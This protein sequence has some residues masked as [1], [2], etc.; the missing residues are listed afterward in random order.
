MVVSEA[1][2]FRMHVSQDHPKIWI[3]AMKIKTFIGN[4]SLKVRFICTKN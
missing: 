2:K 3:E 1:L 4:N